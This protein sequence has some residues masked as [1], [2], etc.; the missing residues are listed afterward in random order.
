MTKNAAIVGLAAYSISMVSLVAGLVAGA[1]RQSESWTVSLYETTAYE[2][3]GMDPTFGPFVGTKDD[4]TREAK[5][6]R[7]TNPHRPAD[8]NLDTVIVVCKMEVAYN[9]LRRPG[10]PNTKKERGERCTQY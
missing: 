10:P 9:G 8:P 2:M 5:S 3:D 6:M 1:S 7:V 4:V